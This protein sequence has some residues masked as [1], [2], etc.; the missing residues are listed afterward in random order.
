MEALISIESLQPNTRIDASKDFSFVNTKIIKEQNDSGPY[1]SREYNVNLR[2]PVFLNRKIVSGFQ[3]K[4]SIQMVLW[5]AYLSFL[6]ITE[7]LWI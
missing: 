2:M 7:W 3:P 4:P 5:T 1:I 6:K